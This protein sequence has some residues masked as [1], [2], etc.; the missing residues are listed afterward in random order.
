MNTEQNFQNG[1]LKREANI[2][3]AT[4]IVQDKNTEANENIGVRTD[5]QQTRNNEPAFDVGSEITDGED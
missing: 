1:N 4:E 3:P 5:E 2:L